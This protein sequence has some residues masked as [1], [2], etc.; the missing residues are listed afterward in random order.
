MIVRTSGKGGKITGLHIGLQ[1]VRQHFPKSITHI[2]LQLGHLH[3]QC[4]LGPEFWIKT[5]EIHDRRLGAWLESRHLRPRGHHGSIELELIKPGDRTFLL[6]AAP[7]KSCSA[8]QSSCPAQDC[9]TCP[10][11]KLRME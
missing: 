11:D 4:E 9:S 6:H 2:D 3:I 7:Q 8:V 10:V 1:N 5:P